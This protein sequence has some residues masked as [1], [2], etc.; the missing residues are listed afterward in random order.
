MLDE[1]QIKTFRAKEYPEELIDIVNNYLKENNAELF[2]FAYL[3]EKEFRLMY[4][5][6]E[7]QKV[8]C[9]LFVYGN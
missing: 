9:Y 1:K 2:N 4:R 6:K 3:G 5:N 7:T 8:N